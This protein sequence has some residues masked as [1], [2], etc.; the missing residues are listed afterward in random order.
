MRRVSE[1]LSSPE[2]LVNF[3][4]NEK[5]YW[6]FCRRAVRGR[7]D[8]SSA[9]SQHRENQYGFKVLKLQMKV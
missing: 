7:S 5:F 3:G 4:G 1:P 9:D 2:P 8:I 6:R